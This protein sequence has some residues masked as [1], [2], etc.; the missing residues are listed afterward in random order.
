VA[1]IV[2]SIGNGVFPEVLNG[3]ESVLSLT[4]AGLQPVLG[5]T[6]YDKTPRSASPARYAC[7]VADG[8]D[9]GRA[10]ITSPQLRKMIEQHGIPGHRVYG[11]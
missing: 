8:G 4:D 9:Y 2:P 7:L 1:V 10:R 5:I 11:H 3:I 6:Q